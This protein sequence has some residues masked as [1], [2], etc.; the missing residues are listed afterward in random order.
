MANVSTRPVCMC[1]GGKFSSARQHTAHE[2]TAVRYDL[3]T[4]HHKLTSPVSDDALL[5]VVRFESIELVIA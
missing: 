5:T 3:E 1:I 2:G 4:Q